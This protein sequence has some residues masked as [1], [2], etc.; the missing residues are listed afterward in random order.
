VSETLRSYDRW[1]AVAPGWERWQFRME[2]F[3]G[4][5]ADWLL[6]ALAPRAGDIVLELA[7]GPGETGFRAA[8]MIGPRGRLI[9]TDFAPRMVEVARRR[10]AALGLRN[11]EHRLMD[12]TR[13]DL[14]AD[15]VD[16]VVCRFGYMLTDDPAA[17]LAEARRVL[18]PGGRV[19]LAVWGPAERNPWLAEAGRILV[20]RGHLPQ[21]APDEPGAFAMADAAA[22]RAL[23][24]AAG[25]AAERMEEVPVRLTFADLDDYLRWASEASGSGLVIRRLPE[26]ERESLR[27][28]L[29]TAF[30]PYAI[31]HGGYALPGLAICAE[32]H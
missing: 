15:S 25:F 27:A 28:E 19:A 31:A 2:E 4:P 21:P 13:L 8:A 3:L 17:A 30:A 16:A 14:E 1:Q 5:V 26:A 29:T 32:A 10:A 7:A 20:R 9:S 24:E 18:R 6:A 11:V 23:I 12:A 22:T